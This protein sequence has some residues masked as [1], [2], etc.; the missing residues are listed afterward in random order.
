MVSTTG[1][2]AGAARR[3]DAHGLR[4]HPDFLRL[5]A[6]LSVSLVG[7]EVTLLAL[8]LAAALTL[9]ASAFQMGLLAAAG[10]AP[11]L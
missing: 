5:W 7:S 1:G 6:A 3:S 10:Q 9:H 2:W 8:P 11:F 4:R